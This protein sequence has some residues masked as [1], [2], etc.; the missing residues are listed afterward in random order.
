[1]AYEKQTWVDNETPLDAEHM[2]H[3]EEGIS[4]LSGEYELIEEINIT[5]DIGRV[6]RTSEPDGTMYNLKQA[7]V[8][9][10]SPEY[11]ENR[12]VYIA[13]GS[14]DS[15]DVWFVDDRLLYFYHTEMINKTGL[16]TLARLINDHGKYLT[17][18]TDPAKIPNIINVKVATYMRS[19]DTETSNNIK[20]IRI[21]ANGN[22]TNLIPTGTK[23]EIWGVRS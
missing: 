21:F 23:I 22:E 19:L 1:M 9:F 8:V 7:Y 13:I 6:I 12:R 17:L 4:E 3:I 11:T 5:E 20:A 14:T 10:T 18:I 2:N 16:T 15:T